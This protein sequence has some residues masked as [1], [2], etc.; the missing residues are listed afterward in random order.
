MTRALLLCVAILPATATAQFNTVINL[1][2]DPDIGDDVRIPNSTQV[3]LAEG[4]T[5]GDNLQLGNTTGSFAVELNMSGGSIGDGASAQPGTLTQIS[6][7]VVGD[8]FLVAPGSSLTL[9]G[10]DFRVDGVPVEGLDDFGDSVAIDQRGVTTFTG[11]LSDGTA[12]MYAFGRT[13][14]KSNVATITFERAAVAPATPGE[15]VISGSNAPLSAKAGQ[16]VRVAAGGVVARNFMAGPTSAVVVEQGGAIGRNLEAIDA[17]ITLRGGTIGDSLEL[18]QGTGLVIDGGSVGD[19]IYSSTGGPVTIYGESFRVAGVEVP[20][21]SQP[22]DEVHLATVVDFTGLLSDGTPIIFSS[23]DDDFLSPAAGVNLRYAAA[24]AATPGTIVASTDP[25]PQGVRGD[26]TLVVDAGSSVGSHFVAGWGATV[27]VQTGAAIGRNFEAIGTNVNV[28]GGTIGPAMDAFEGT[29]VAVDNGGAIGEGFEAVQSDVDLIDG[30]IG[31]NATIGDGAS[32][33]VSGGSVG[34][35]LSIRR[36][37][38][39]KVT[40]GVIGQFFTAFN[41]ER[42]EVTGGVF[43]ASDDGY[44]SPPRLSRVDSIEISGGHFED[45]LAIDDSGPLVLSGGG[46]TAAWNSR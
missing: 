22:G 43:R 29:G 30:S 36:G 27:N 5:I 21:L 42:V 25:V 8:D 4:G 9:V 7:G 24:P 17:N 12:F 46:S 11:V 44:L 16:T 35:N 45:D 15:I 6:G 23:I 13:D 32:L 31:D 34:E 40:G 14:R 18:I 39:L 1:P 26:Q 3:N 33:H 19:G 10:D 20:G 41:A 2:P 28:E 38:S 37:G